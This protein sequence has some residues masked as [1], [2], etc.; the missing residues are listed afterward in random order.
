[1]S[2]PRAQVTKTDAKRNKWPKVRQITRA[3]GVTAWRVDSRINGIGERLFYKS[4]AEADTKAEQLR[5]KRL[6]EGK[7]SVVFSESHR[8][9]AERCIAKL[10]EVGA[11]LDQATD[12]FLKHTRPKAGARTVKIL[13]AEFLKAKQLAGRRANYLSV[14]KYVLGVFERTFGE[15]EVH[16]IGHQEIS[17][18]MHAKE[19]GLRTRDNY[20]RDLGN[21][22][23]FAIKHNYATVN[24]LEKIEVATLDD[25]PPGILTVEQCSTLLFTA[26]EFEEGVMLP[27]VAIGLFCGLRA[28]ELAALDWAEVSLPERTVEVTAAKA[29]TRTRRNVTISDNLAAWL[30][31]HNR[32]NGPIAPQDDLAYTWERLRKAAGLRIKKTPNG[33][34]GIP[35]PKNA[36]R[37]SFASYHVAHHKNAPLTSLEMGHDNPNQLFSAYREL[38]KPKAAAAFW[39]LAP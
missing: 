3:T 22:F 21:L 38:V 6:N 2:T 7:A 13:A 10:A 14:Q 29:K 5:V 16:T 30:A 35:W 31:P 9:M 26:A 23:N 15:R 34:T 20:R 32:L 36:M 25:A 24:P 33:Q 17:D 19:W 8:I 18:W 4:A 27:Y 39:E 37:H 28:S 1:M 11:D 12:F